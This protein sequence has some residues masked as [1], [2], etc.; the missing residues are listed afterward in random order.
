MNNFFGTQMTR[1]GLIYTDKNLKICFN[2]FNL[3]H[4]C[5]F[6]GKYMIITWTKPNYTDYNELRALAFGRYLTAV[7]RIFFLCVEDRLIRLK[8]KGE[9]WP[10][11]TKVAQLK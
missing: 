2:P 10:G 1:I 7:L 5:S 3:C 4:P 6:F 11:S 9:F 8:S